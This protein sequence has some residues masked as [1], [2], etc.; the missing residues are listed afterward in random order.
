MSVVIYEQTQ[1]PFNRYTVQG[2]LSG[3]TG[4]ECST[5][6]K[7]G[8]HRNLALGDCSSRERRERP[9]PWAT[10]LS[11]RYSAG[12]RQSTQ[13]CQVWAD[14]F[15]F[16]YFNESRE[17]LIIAS[18][19]PKWSEA[20][21]RP[22]ARGAGQPVPPQFGHCWWWFSWCSGTC[23]GSG[24]GFHSDTRQSFSLRNFE[25]GMI[26]GPSWLRSV[27]TDDTAWPCETPTPTNLNLYSANSH[28]KTSQSA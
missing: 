27:L 19:H 26:W 14:V 3:L 15:F 4:F 18:T 28:P 21:V 2:V 12:W 20:L 6:K 5:V 17:L 25:P 23:N 10:A 9:L 8:L 7:S 1:L 11:R 24:P 16:L 13:T 22:L